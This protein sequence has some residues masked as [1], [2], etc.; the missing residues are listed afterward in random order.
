MLFYVFIFIGEFKKKNI[1][2]KTILTYVQIVQLI[3]SIIDV[4]NHFIFIL[5]GNSQF[6][7]VRLDLFLEL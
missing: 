2:Q 7:G 3:S 5:L 4:K 1:S 6:N